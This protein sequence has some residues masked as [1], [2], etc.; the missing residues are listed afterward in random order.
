[1]EIKKLIAVFNETLNQEGKF[2]ID[3]NTEFKEL[4]SWSSLSAF[5]LVEKVFLEFNVKLRGIEIRKCNTINDLF[6]LLKT[7]CA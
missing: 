5:E 6:E 3:E 2:T 1:M 4:D 7:K